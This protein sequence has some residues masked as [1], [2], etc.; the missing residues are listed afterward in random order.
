MI[1]RIVKM[2]FQ[3]EKV[4]D[5]LTLFENTKQ[6]ISGFEGCEHLK[7]LNDINYPTVYFTYSKWESIEHLEKYRQS[8][9]FANVWRNTKILFSQKAEAWSVK[10]V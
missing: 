2:T 1:T 5:F 10:E 8:D 4:T 7:L 3:P 6:K 9:L